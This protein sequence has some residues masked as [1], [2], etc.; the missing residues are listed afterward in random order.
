[1]KL[2]RYRFD[3]LTKLTIILTVIYL[4]SISRTL[5]KEKDRKGD[6]PRYRTAYACEGSQ[7]QI[8]CE[9]GTLIHLIRANY[10][11]FSISICNEHGNLDWSVDCTSQR[12]YYVIA[13]SCGMKKSCTLSASSSLFDDPCPGTLKYLEAHYQ[14]VPESATTITN[15]TTNKTISGPIID[16]NNIVV[17]APN[18]QSPLSPSSSTT[19]STPISAS[20]TSR[21]P[22]IIPLTQTYRT[23]IPTSTTTTPTTPFSNLIPGE[24]HNSHSS[25]N[26]NDNSNSN[27]P[28]ITSSENTTQRSAS[29]NATTKVPPTSST[30]TIRSQSESTT[31]TWSSTT[32]R[33]KIELTT[34]EHMSSTDDISTVV[35]GNN[36]EGDTM[37]SIGGIVSYDDHLNHNNNR[38]HQQDHPF[39]SPTIV[40]DIR[41]SPTRAGHVDIEPCPS[42]THGSAK[43]ECGHHPVEWLSQPDLSDCTSY[44]AHN[45][46]SRVDSGDSVVSVASELAQRTR[47]SRLYGGDVIQTV[48]ILQS[49]VNKMGS[50]VGDIVEEKQRHQVVKELIQSVIE[51]SSN[52]LE[53]RNRESWFDIQLGSRRGIASQLIHELENSA[54]LLAATHNGQYDFNKA[55]ANVLVS[56]RLVESNVPGIRE[57]HFPDRK[58][59]V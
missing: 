56:V 24:S 51:V 10:G 59:V 14:C 37:G 32:S 15:T 35:V 58:S 9:P 40:R 36:I 11:R 22:I 25:F 46:R 19:M 28:V 12:S 43:W 13:N 52:L 34:S 55:H 47:G 1:M 53:T 44:W 54:L 4:S 8:S 45:L 23:T 20:T 41:W 27:S 48:H 42:P 18:P 38:Q 39:C 49:L 57:M 6:R 2:S 17:L 26:T 21:P 33:P 30:T 3:N 50:S 7:L 31:S 16:H 5:A 29:I